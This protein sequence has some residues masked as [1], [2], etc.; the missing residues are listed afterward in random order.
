MAQDWDWKGTFPIHE[1]PKTVNPKT[2]TPVPLVQRGGLYAG[3][4]NDNNIFLYGGTTSYPNTSFPNYEW[5]GPPIYTL[6]SFDTVLREWNQYDSQ[7]VS[8]DAPNRPNAG[9]WDGAPD[10]GLAFYFNG[11]V[12]S[13]S[14][15]STQYLGSESYSLDGMV[16]IDTSNQT[17]RNLST[18]NVVRG[19]PRTRGKMTYLPNIGTNG[20]LVVLGGTSQSPPK[21]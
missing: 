16:V 4:P 8:R 10:Q 7:Q 5:P 12:D 6:W 15:S 20:I 9:V 18:Q 1:I 2:G 3:A 13:G 21:Q 17:A 11:Q 14:S 19:A